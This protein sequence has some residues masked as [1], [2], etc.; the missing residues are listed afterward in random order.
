[1]IATFLVLGSCAK[2]FNMRLKKKMDQM[3]MQRE[4]LSGIS[5]NVYAMD[6]STMPV[7]TSYKTG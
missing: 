4:R 7:W 1:M 2:L 5:G 3:K 6:S